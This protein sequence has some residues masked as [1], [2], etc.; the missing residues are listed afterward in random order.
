M[1]GMSGVGPGES[2]RFAGRVAVV[3][4]AGAGLGA[5]SVAARAREGAAVVAVDQDATGAERTTEATR[6]AGGE[7]RAVT[8]DLAREDEVA[9][10]VGGHAHAQMYPRCRQS[11]SAS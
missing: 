6:A 5:L 9:R 10:R 8:A 11:G 3:T 7:C 4:G 1:T 2:S